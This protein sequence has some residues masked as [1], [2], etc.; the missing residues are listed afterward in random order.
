[1]QT[2]T[3]QI[4]TRITKFAIITAV[5]SL[6]FGSIPSPTFANPITDRSV[7]IGSSV[8]GATTSYSFQFTVPSATVIQSASFTACTTA[9]GA[10]T[11]PSLF[12]GSGAS[13]AS[14][15]VNLGD[16]SGWTGNFAT[17]GSLRVTKSGNVAAPTGNQTVAFLGVVNP[18]L[19]NQTYFFRITTYSDAAWTTPIDTG[20]VATSTAGQITVNIPIDEVLTFTLASSTTT[21]TA[22][23]P[24][25][26]G[27]GTSTMSISTNARS[28]Y[29]ITYNGLAPSDGFTSLTGMPYGTSVVN[30]K[31]FGLN[32]V[33]NST[34]AVGTAVSGS[35]SGVAYGDYA[36]AD[37]FKFLSGDQVASAS[38]PTN[39]NTF[40]VSYIANMDGS[41]SAGVYQTILNYV[42]TANF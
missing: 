13:L 6:V 18:T 30:S 22:P 21:L 29:S 20:T 33:A 12:S 9:S 17:D 16:G 32:L 8:S 26:T 42:A 31:Q 35:G 14:Q 41:T 23:T 38:A 4:H 27:S 1:M 19:T 5:F 37:N 34:P 7:T 40:T 3:S 24:S 11:K 25:T 15:P 2:K 10:C 36:S 39:T 28:G